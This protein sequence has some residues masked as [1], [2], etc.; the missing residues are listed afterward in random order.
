MKFLM[1]MIPRVY[2]PSTPAGE[3]AGDDFLPSL[4]AVAPMGRFNDELAKAGKIL[5]LEGLQPLSKGARVTFSNGKATVTDGPFIETK[6]VIGGYWIVEMNSKEELLEWAQ[7]C[8]AENG[9]VIEIRPIFEFP[10]GFGEK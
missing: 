7:R 2:Q 9:D 8:P 1:M 4:E 10:E 3:R 5:D 6:D